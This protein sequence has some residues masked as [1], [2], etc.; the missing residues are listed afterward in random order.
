MSDSH[1]DAERMRI[2]DDEARDGD[3]PSAYD[4]GVSVLAVTKTVTTYPTT[5]GTYV[6]CE[7]RMVLGTEIEGTAGVGTNQGDTFYAYIPTGAT[8]P[9]S[10]SEV[11]CVGCGNRWVLDV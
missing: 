9:A 7:T 6:A 3:G 10:G 1:D 11:V 4:A 8:I 2:E 5:A